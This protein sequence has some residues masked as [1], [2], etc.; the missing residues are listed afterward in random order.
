MIRIVKDVMTRPSVTFYED[1]SLQQCLQTFVEK[2][3]DGTL[4]F[5]YLDELVG[6]LTVKDLL[7]GLFFQRK[8]IREVMTAPGEVL[9]EDERIESVIHYTGEIHPV[10]NGSNE[11]I[12]CITHKQL[13]EVYSE[14]TQEK[15]SLMDAIFN[16]AHNGIMSIDE[17]GYITSIN[18]AAERMAGTTAEKA[19]GQYITNVVATPGLLEVLKTG[20]PYSAKYQVG[21]RKYI[22]NRTP[23]IRGGKV[24]GAVGVFQ[25]ISEI[26]FVS[27]ELSSV[28]NILHE[29]DI[30]L[31]S[32]YDAILI[33]DD[34]GNIIKANHSFL[35]I[36]GLEYIP[37]CYESLVGDTFES[38]IVSAVLANQQ[39]VTVMERNKKNQNL[40]MITG[41]PVI[42]MEGKVYRVVITIQNVTEIDN[43][44]RE[45][46]EARRH[47][48][49]LQGEKN[50]SHHLIAT[51]PGMKRVIQMVEQIAKVDS[52][53]L[54]LGESGVGKEE[55][56]K[57]IHQY[58][59][60]KDKPFVKV[61]CGAIPEQ[62]LE[63]ELFGYEQGA[64]TGANKGGKTGLFESANKGT[65]FLDEIGEL[66]LLLQV[67][68]LRVLQEKEITRV[69]GVKPRK[70][71]VRIIAATNRDLKEL[72]EKGEF[73]KDLYYRLNVVPIHVPPLRERVEDIPLLLGMFQQRFSQQY[74]I[75]KFF[76]PKAVQALIHY[77]WPGNV[78]ELANVVERL[79]V[80][81]AGPT[82]E[83]KDVKMVLEEEAIGDENSFVYVSGI[84]PLKEAIDEV[85]KQLLTKALRMYKNTRRTAEILKVDQSTIVRKLKKY[86]GGTIGSEID[87]L[88]H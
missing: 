63:S 30:V 58:S 1:D 67:K 47:L 14:L 74:G 29:L 73:R 35:R 87:M 25:D 65:I 75:E 34:Q 41:T 43:L 19:I 54:I 49:Q 13:I 24:V 44:R 62:L 48:S 83:W 51:S 8:T 20:K 31:E 12:G 84:M 4:V 70:I 60:R 81:T 6:A 36:L 40:L 10:K 82:I 76:S 85:E 45:L 5:N 77:R 50:S 39:T 2:D 86:R 33:T 53:V 78:R 79:I 38:S 7:K 28:K 42:D 18:P 66:P 27:A 52:T 88:N 37:K 11:L 68:L 16:S 17:K 22:S 26:E 46:D 71:D 15:L 32:S 55:I 3:L 59:D 57:L 56:S 80:M 72:V 64:F 23:I 21:K 9:N 61:N 69:G